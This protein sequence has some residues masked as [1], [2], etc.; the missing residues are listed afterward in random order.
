[1][2]T[3]APQTVDTGTGVPPLLSLDTLKRLHKPALIDHCTSLQDIA[4]RQD[5]VLQGACASLALMNSS[6]STLLA[7]L[8]ALVDAFDE[9]DH[10]AI[11]VQLR[12]LSERRK[13]FKKPEVH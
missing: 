12:Q 11:Y 9:A 2:N 5:Q 10:N 6:S 7:I 4:R 3:P 8:Y 13:S 1:M